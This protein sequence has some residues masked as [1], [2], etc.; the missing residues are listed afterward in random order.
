MSITYLFAS[1]ESILK[2]NNLNF[3]SHEKSTKTHHVCILVPRF[4]SE[5]SGELDDIISR[6][7]LIPVTSS[8]LVSIFSPVSFSHA[9]SHLAESRPPA[10]DSLGIAL[11]ALVPV[12]SLSSNVELG[13]SLCKGDKLTIEDS[14]HV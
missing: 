4:L 8:L 2:N 1:Q 12:R 9:F 6:H 14:D 7:F 3:I 13:W 5:D 11:D 10:T